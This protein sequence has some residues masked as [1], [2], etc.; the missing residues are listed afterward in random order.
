MSKIHRKHQKDRRYR[1]FRRECIWQPHTSRLYEC[2]A[3]IALIPALR[4]MTLC[5]ISRRIHQIESPIRTQSLARAIYSMQYSMR[6][7]RAMWSKRWF[8][9][10]CDV[11]IVLFCDVNLYKTVRYTIRFHNSV[12][13]FDCMILRCPSRDVSLGYL[14]IY[15]GKTTTINTSHKGWENHTKRL[16]VPPDVSTISNQPKW[17]WWLLSA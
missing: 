6:S 9:N 12:I 7:K 4:A 16:N 13:R 2:Q 1:I 5:S 11:S 14:S 3:F 8:L 15:S 10:S 17:T